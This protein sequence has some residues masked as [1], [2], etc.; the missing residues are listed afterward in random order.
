M[1]EGSKVMPSYG[2]GSF[3]GEKEITTLP[4]ARFMILSKHWESTGSG[5]RMVIETMLLPHHE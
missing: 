5:K 2:S 1:A 3:S 4:Y